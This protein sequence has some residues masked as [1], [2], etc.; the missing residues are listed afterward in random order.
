LIL[1]LFIV[2][3]AAFIKRT[4]ATL[5]PTVLLSP[6]L[7]IALTAIAAYIAFIAYPRGSVLLGFS[8]LLP[9]W[10][11]LKG[12]EGSRHVVVLG[13]TGSGKTET[14][15]RLISGRQSVLVLDWAGEYTIFPVVKPEELSLAGLTVEEIVEAIGNAFQLTTPQTGFLYNILKNVNVANLKVVVERLQSLPEASL[16]ASEREIRAAL[17]RRLTPCERL[18]GGSTPLNVGRVN[19]SHLTHDGKVLTLNVALRIIYDLARRRELQAEVVVIEEAQNV[20]PA[21]REGPPSSGELLLQEM[22]KYGISVVLSA[23]LPATLSEYFRDAEYVIVH[24]LLMNSDEVRNFAT[25]LDEDDFQRLSRAKTGEALVLHRGEKLWVRVLKARQTKR[26][27]PEIA[28]EVKQAEVEEGVKRAEFEAKLFEVAKGLEGLSELVKELSDS[29]EK[30]T[31]RAEDLEVFKEGLEKIMRGRV[32]NKLDLNEFKDR[33]EK[34]LNIV[35][36]ELPS[37]FNKLKELTSKVE[38]LEGE[39]ATVKGVYDELSEQVKAILTALNV[40]KGGLKRIKPKKPLTSMGAE[41][42]ENELRKVV[43]ALLRDPPTLSVADM[44]DRIVIS[45]ARYIDD[46]SF[47]AVTEVVKGFGGRVERDD[48]GFFWAIPKR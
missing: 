31:K 18:F 15:K 35:S 10:I 1:A 27:Q 41:A 47:K 46:E 34:T 11:K 17:L 2:L 32:E 5:D 33:V 20:I 4:L 25:I 36:S 24:R 12:S 44:G 39:I 45:P 13:V 8:R 29:V 6:I 43:P 42:V 40:L 21:K 19:L 48:R 9:V 23:Q 7:F 30:L 3:V 22:R 16:S 28:P 26:K 37:A 38:V 14:V